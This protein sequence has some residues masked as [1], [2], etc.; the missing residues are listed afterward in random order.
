MEFVNFM[1]YCRDLKFDE[2]PDYNMLRRE[3]K[4]LFNSRGFEYD[5]VFDWNILDRK[6]RRA[7][8]K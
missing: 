5:Y 2:K 6:K 4:N 3:F 1:K 8:V 7:S